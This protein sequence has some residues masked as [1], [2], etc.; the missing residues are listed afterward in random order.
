ME[1]AFLKAAGLF[2]A[3]MTGIVKAIPVGVALSMSIFEIGLYVSLGSIVTVLIIYFS[4]E[5]LKRWITKKWS[6]EKM[7]KKKGKFSI[8][9]ERYGV[10]GVGLLT[11]GTLGPITSIII[12]LILLK[13][14]SNLMPYLVV[15]II[16]W[17]YLLAWVGV[18]GFDLVKSLS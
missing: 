12:G 4:G 14:T 18:E 16:V 17:S 5:P 7:D 8:L 1:D 11:P 9:L 2:L 13:D 15:G 10:V 6:K 3:G